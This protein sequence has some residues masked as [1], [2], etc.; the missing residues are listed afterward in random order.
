MRPQTN[1]GCV[2]II[3]VG[4]ILLLQDNTWREVVG[5]AATTYSHP[6]IPVNVRH[7]SFKFRYCR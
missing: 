3:E 5:F 1:E 2:S 7:S 4:D 6:D